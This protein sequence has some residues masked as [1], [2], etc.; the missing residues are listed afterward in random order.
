MNQG[1]MNQIADGMTVYDAGGERVG[2]VRQYDAQNGYLEVEKGWLFHKDFYVPMN[3]VT[4]TDENGVYLNV[5]KDDLSAGAYDQP[6]TGAGYTTT[7][8]T[9][10][11]YAATGANTVASDYTTTDTVGTGTANT[12]GTGATMRSQATTTDTND[13]VVPEY[14]EELVVGK[15]QEE[16]GEVHLHKDVVEEQET[17]AVN[18]RREEVTVERVPVSGDAIDP[19][20]AQDAFKNA[21]I[22]VPVMG[23][24]AVVGKRAHEV[25]EVR[26]RKQTFE[27]QQ[28]VSD[29]VRK[30]RVVVDGDPDELVRDSGLRND[31]MQR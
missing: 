23:E 30:E 17:I 28:Q 8:T 14:Q 16:I 3:V 25:E 2:K 7:S 18:L 13:I 4:R 26:L 6:P 12:M 9:A 29:T 20:T 15:R 11:D 1:A 5:Y 24:E 27:D 19:N 22:E 10:T 21:D 31:D